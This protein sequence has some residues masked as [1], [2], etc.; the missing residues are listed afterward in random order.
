MKPVPLR[1]TSEKRPRR[2]KRSA[3]LRKL[4]RKK[5]QREGL[6]PMKPRVIPAPPEEPA[7][8]RAP[9]LISKPVENPPSSARWG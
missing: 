5:L 8:A 2:R 6:L 7:L 4:A 3:A 1:E 9:F